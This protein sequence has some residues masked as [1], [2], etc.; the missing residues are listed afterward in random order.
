M[1]QG[2]RQGNMVKRSPYIPE[3]GDIVWV[4]LNPQKGN[5]QAH[6]RPAIVMSPK[7][8]NRKSGLA[9]MCPVTSR[10]KSYPFEVMFTGEKVEGV[11]LSD[12]MRSLDWRA[13]RVAFIQK[14]KPEILAAVQELIVQLIME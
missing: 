11:V 2:A 9:L 7:F 12:Q 5:E 1:G 4:N 10:A 3:R 14:L 13:R 6:Q 8:Y